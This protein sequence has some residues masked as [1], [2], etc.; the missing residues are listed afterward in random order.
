MRMCRIA[1]HLRRQPDCLRAEARTGPIGHRTIKR[2]TGK[3]E[4]P[5]ETR[6]AP[7]GLNWEM[8]LGQTPLVDYVPERCH[9]NFRYW[10]EYSGGTMTDWGAHHLDIAQWGTGNDRSGPV[11]IEAK[12]G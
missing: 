7:A 6:P 11:S 10:W 2:Q 3:R 9:V 8:W 12:P 1:Q 4:G 5:F